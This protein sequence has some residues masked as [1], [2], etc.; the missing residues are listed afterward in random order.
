V[1]EETAVAQRQGLPGRKELIAE[2]LASTDVV[3]NQSTPEGVERVFRMVDAI[4][5]ELHDV[6]GAEGLSPRTIDPEKLRRATA[7]A[8]TGNRVLATAVAKLCQVL[9]GATEV[10]VDPDRAGSRDHVAIARSGVSWLKDQHER[11][12]EDAECMMA[13][14]IRVLGSLV[15]AMSELRREVLT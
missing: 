6:F 9:A 4:N 1:G 8:I 13:V 15:E 10:E 12:C 14:Q 7:L 2:A 11:D 3:A 5:Q